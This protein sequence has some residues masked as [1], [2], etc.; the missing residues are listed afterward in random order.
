MFF[1]KEKALYDCEPKE[2]RPEAL[3]RLYAA[4]IAK[5]ILVSKELVERH[6]AFAAL[7]IELAECKDALP[8]EKISGH[9]KDALEFKQSAQR[10]ADIHNTLVKELAVLKS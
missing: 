3:N 5:L 2:L 6:D 7:S 4:L 10:I 9:L 1:K 8:K